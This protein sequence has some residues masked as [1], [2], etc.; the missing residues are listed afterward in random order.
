[1]DAYM[2][3]VY[4]GGHGELGPNNMKNRVKKFFKRTKKLF[5]KGRALHQICDA[6]QDAQRLAKEL[7]ELR[8]RYGVWTRGIRGWCGECH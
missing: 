8:Q 1:M 6:V 4:D 7:G 5:S 3:S 2:V